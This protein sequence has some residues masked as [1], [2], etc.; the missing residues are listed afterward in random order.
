MQI[1]GKEAF[2]SIS[3]CF[4]SWHI[5]DTVLNFIIKSTLF[6][7]DKLTY[8]VVWVWKLLSITVKCFQVKWFLFV[9]GDDFG[10]RS[11]LI[12]SKNLTLSKRN[13]KDFQ[14]RAKTQKS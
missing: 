5:Y 6:Q 1:Y 9:K 3:M 12:L 4:S 11:S 10:K 7:T 8:G 14:V 13:S 2:A